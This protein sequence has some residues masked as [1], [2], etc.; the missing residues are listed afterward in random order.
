M[1]RQMLVAIAWLLPTISWANPALETAAEL[2]GRALGS[3]EAYS[4]LGYLCDNFGPRISG[5]ELLEQAI[6]W[7]AEE[8]K[9]DGLTTKK[10]VVT[11]PKWVRGPA[12]AT[13]CPASMVRLRPWYT[14][15]SRRDG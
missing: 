6:D 10:E 8:L 4:E 11:V 15:S 2:G 1:T 9:K 7:A 12:S 3:D 13:V 14:G 5:S